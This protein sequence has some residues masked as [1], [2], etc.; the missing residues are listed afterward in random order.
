MADDLSWRY[1]YTI[2]RMTGFAISDDILEQFRKKAT[3]LNHVLVVQAVTDLYKSCW[4]D[5]LHQLEGDDYSNMQDETNKL[6]RLEQAFKKD[7]EM[8]LCAMQEVLSDDDYDH[9]SK[10]IKKADLREE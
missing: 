2:L 10:I 8:L 9:F 4:D 5:M 7:P 1:K 3:N 6:R